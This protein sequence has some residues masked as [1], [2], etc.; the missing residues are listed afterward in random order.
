MKSIIYFCLLV[1]PASIFAQDSIQ[2]QDPEAEP[3][4]EI[5]AGKF[6]T[7]EPYQVEFRYEIYSAMHD[8][9]VTDYGSIIVKGNMY[10]LKTEDT[11]VIYNGKHLWVYNPEAGE[12]YKSEPEEGNPDQMLADP[13]RLLGEY[14][15]HYKYLY[16][17][18]KNIAGNT[19]FQID[20]YPENLDANYS[21]L[22]ILCTEGEYD[23]HSITMKQKNGTEITAYINDLIKNIKIPE[24]TF[25]WNEEAH[26]D[27][28][29]IEM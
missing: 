12:V 27:I 1:L 20:L 8:A 28:L 9:R 26:P 29:L 13:F 7:T 5:I 24:S 6:K 22:R 25:V 4:L 19:F 16:K 21:L 15:K 23:V 11:E 14:K 3:F 10:K 17:G 2:A 18:E